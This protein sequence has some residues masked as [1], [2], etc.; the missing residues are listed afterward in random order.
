MDNPVTLIG[1]IIVALVL[2]MITHLLIKES[3][4]KFIFN[5]LQSYPVFNGILNIFDKDYLKLIFNIGFI[6]ILNII[7]VFINKAIYKKHSNN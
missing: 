7:F 3:E 5:I 6:L 2:P 1:I 4:Y